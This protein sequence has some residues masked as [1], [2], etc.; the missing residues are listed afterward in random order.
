MKSSTRRALLLLGLLVTLGL[1][2]W[3]QPLAGLA[4]ALALVFG[5]LLWWLSLRPSNEGRLGAGIRRDALGGNRR[6]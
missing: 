6:R 4:I 2:V 5:F 1:A 3:W